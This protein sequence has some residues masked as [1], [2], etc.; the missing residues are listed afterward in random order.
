MTY[1]AVKIPNF[2]MLLDWGHYQ[3]FSQ[4]YGHPVLNRI[5]VKNPVTDSTF[6]SL[7]N[8]KRYLNLLQKF[9]KFS[10]IPS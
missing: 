8:F 4:L 10:K 2:C 5:R 9:D 1:L 7:K 3:Q 6:E